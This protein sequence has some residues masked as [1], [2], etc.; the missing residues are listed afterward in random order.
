MISLLKKCIICHY[1][2]FSIKDLTFNE[3]C[4]LTLRILVFQILQVFIISPLCF[5][6]EKMMSDMYIFKY[7][8][9]IKKGESL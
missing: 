8:G 9:L 4:L 1:Q 3:Q 2:Y 6:L 7:A 5:D